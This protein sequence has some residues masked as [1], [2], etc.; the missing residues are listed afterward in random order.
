MV[1][2]TVRFKPADGP[3]QMGVIFL[4]REA[5]GLEIL[6]NWD[7][8][9]MRASGS[10]D[11]VFRDVFVPEMMAMPMSPWGEPGLFFRLSVPGLPGLMA[12]FLGIAEAAHESVV[13]LLRSRR[14]APS[15]RTMAE[16]APAQAMV[17]ESEIGL[18]ACRAMLARTSLTIDATL[19]LPGDEV[20][21]C[22]HD[23][24]KD[25]Q[26]TKTF[27]QRTSIEVVD[28]ALTLSG[29]SGYL[30]ASPLSRLYRDVRA[31]PFMQPYSPNEA[32]EYIGKV[33]LGL[34]PGID[35]S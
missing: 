29:G 17:A 10:G 12:V 6:D 31:G 23:L 3:E 1:M 18:A 2:S 15:N 19:A 13:N 25:I 30:T 4:P 27:L 22:I 5:D 7:A 28:R 24:N 34:D 20:S 32:F 35:V 16:R 33:A 11:V 8:L 14:K 21:E 9:G 26:C